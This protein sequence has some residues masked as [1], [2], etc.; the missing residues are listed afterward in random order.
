MAAAHVIGIAALLQEL[1]PFMSGLELRG[2]VINHVTDLGDPGR[3]VRFGAGLVDACA[4]ARTL[5]ADAVMCEEDV[6]PS[7]FLIDE[8][9]APE[10]GGES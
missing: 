5:T 9:A 6:E 2:A 10:Q 3:D 4:A 7:P 1:S 8:L